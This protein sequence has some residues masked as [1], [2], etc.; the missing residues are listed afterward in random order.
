MEDYLNDKIQTKA[1]L[2]DL[3]SLIVKVEEQ[4]KILQNQVSR[5]RCSMSSS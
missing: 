2:K 3:E 1:D 5:I 4:K